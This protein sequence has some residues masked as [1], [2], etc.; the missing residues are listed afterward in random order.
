MVLL[1]RLKAETQKSIVVQSIA[2]RSLDTSV[3]ILTGTK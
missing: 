3:S 2:V 1:T